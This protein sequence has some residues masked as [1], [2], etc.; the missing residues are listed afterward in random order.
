VPQ[1][2]TLPRAQR[3]TEYAGFIVTLLFCYL[4]ALS[5]DVT[6]VR[7]EIALAESNVLVSRVASYILL[8]ASSRLLSQ[9]SRRNLYATVF[10]TEIKV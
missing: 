5:T 7:L 3:Q 2:I 1:A 4:S 9:H 6:P 8:F 10:R